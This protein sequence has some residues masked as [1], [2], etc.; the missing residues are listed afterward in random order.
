MDPVENSNTQQTPNVPI[1]SP[2]HEGFE[3]NSDKS[4]ESGTDPELSIHSDVE[5][6]RLSTHQDDPTDGHPSGSAARSSPWEAETSS[7]DLEQ[8]ASL[9]LVSAET[10]C[11][12]SEAR[13]RDVGPSPLLHYM[14]STYDEKCPSDS[15]SLEVKYFQMDTAKAVK[16]TRY[17]EA[18][19]RRGNESSLELNNSCSVE[20]AAGNSVLFTEHSATV[21]DQTAVDFS[22]QPHR[23]YPSSW[24]R[25]YTGVEVS[26]ALASEHALA[27]KADVPDDRELSEDS[28][29]NV[30]IVQ[31]ISH[32]SLAASNVSADES[33]QNIA[34]ARFRDFGPPFDPAVINRNKQSDHVETSAGPRTEE[35]GEVPFKMNQVRNYVA[36]A[37]QNAS[38]QYKA[39]TD[40]SGK[41]SD[42]SLKE[43]RESVA[44]ATL[45]DKVRNETESENPMEK[46]LV[47]AEF[48]T[49]DF[50]DNSQNRATSLEKDQGTTLE[51]SL[52][53]TP[54]AEESPNS[55]SIET[56][57]AQ[58]ELELPFNEAT[59]SPLSIRLFSHERSPRTFKRL[60]SL[61][62][63]WHSEEV[64]IN[65]Q[66]MEPQE[67][68]TCSEEMETERVAAVSPPRDIPSVSSTEACTPFTEHKDDDQ[69]CVPGAPIPIRKTLNTLSKSE[70]SSPSV[71]F[72]T[73]CLSV[74]SPMST[75]GSTAA[76]HSGPCTSSLSVA[77]LTS[78][79]PSLCVDMRTGIGFVESP[80]FELTSGTTAPHPTPVSSPAS[81]QA[82]PLPPPVR[83]P[84]FLLTEPPMLAAPWKT[85]SQ[86][87][88]AHLD[89]RSATEPENQM[90]TST[91]APGMGTNQDGEVTSHNRRP[92]RRVS[93]VNSS[94]RRLTPYCPGVQGLLT[95]AVTESCLEKLATIKG[96]SATAPP[97]FIVHPITGKEIKIV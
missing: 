18:K 9:Y 64:F 87:S 85:S 65:P 81:E 27:K 46:G 51:T 1:S 17:F 13:R 24:N 5:H 45:T 72:S 86:T 42:T 49:E 35:A 23:S 38:A 74:K 68:E 11:R 82:T 55:A 40:I 19:G 36:E 58:Q 28:G 92:S 33:D 94:S 62:D 6:E 56:F 69:L 30:D 48:S 93:V 97:L 4:L 29:D 2:L 14:G 32:I 60:E 31:G 44:P 63:P 73:A 41:S 70:A 66:P 91:L 71:Y 90:K 21:N 50:T 3:Q 26:G 54:S 10:S 89:H 25:S 84:T 61:E 52:Q 78:G 34:V 15:E 57:R 39:M 95:P 47:K 76:R 7:S 20:Q 75:R 8:S 53:V 79:L 67:L 16:E 83:D 96:K 88:A 22:T 12:A 80:L 37:V 43:N 59:F 77:R